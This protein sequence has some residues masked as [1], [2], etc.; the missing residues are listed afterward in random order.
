MVSY[1]A[2]NDDNNGNNGE[3]SMCDVTTPH[4]F[5][6]LLEVAVSYC[7]LPSAEMAVI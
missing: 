5:S 4:I 1:E 3:W 2:Q 6:T 7:P